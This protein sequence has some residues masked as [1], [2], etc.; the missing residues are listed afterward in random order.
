MNITENFGFMTGRLTMKTISKDVLWKALEKKCDTRE[1]L[2][3]FSYYYNITSRVN[4]ELILVYQW[5][6]YVLIKY[7]QEL[8]SQYIF[9]ARDIVIVGGSKKNEK[10]E[11]RRQTLETYILYKPN[12]SKTNYMDYKFRKNFRNPTIYVMIGD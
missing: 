4:I 1:G 3:N 12:S 11:M 6:W 10:L 9:F 5:S 2:D 8:M 7:I